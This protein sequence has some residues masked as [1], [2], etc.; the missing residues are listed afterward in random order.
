VDYSLAWVLDFW[1]RSTIDS[2]GG[3]IVASIV[4]IV[5]FARYLPSIYTSMV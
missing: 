3:Y 1:Q 2:T 5:I 4:G